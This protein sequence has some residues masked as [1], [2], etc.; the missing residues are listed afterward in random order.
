MFRKSA[1]RCV[2]VRFSFRNLMRFFILSSYSQARK[3]IRDGSAPQLQ[4][5]LVRAHARQGATG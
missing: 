1:F 3:Q 2:L 4:A 5:N